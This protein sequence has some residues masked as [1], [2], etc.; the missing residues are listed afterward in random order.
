MGNAQKALGTAMTVGNAGVN[1]SP[2]YPP[3]TPADIAAFQKLVAGI[4]RAIGNVRRTRRGTNS[5]CPK[6]TAAVAAVK[7]ASTMSMKLMA[8]NL[9]FSQATPPSLGNQPIGASLSSTYFQIL[10]DTKCTP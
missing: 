9:R 10:P 1:L 6:W 3:Q 5:T 7:V 4:G 8:Q 2:P